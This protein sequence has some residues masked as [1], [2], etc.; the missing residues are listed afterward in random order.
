MPISGAL[1]EI[2][3]NELKIKEGYTDENGKYSTTL[4]AGVYRI[5]VS[6]AGYNTIE[7]TETI[8]ATTELLVNLPAGVVYEEYDVEVTISTLIDVAPETPEL[9]SE[10][11]TTVT[12][13]VT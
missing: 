9:L 1:V 7:K 6:K 10:I 3:K 12:T 5:V 8:G 11:T 4:D 13:E 2:Y